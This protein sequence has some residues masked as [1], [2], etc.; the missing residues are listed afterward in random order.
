MPEGPPVPEGSQKEVAMGAVGG[1]RRQHD[2]LP[3]LALDPGHVDALERAV[4]TGTRLVDQADGGTELG[5]LG[6]VG[7]HGQVPGGNPCGPCS[8]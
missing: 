3:D 2:R 4:P 7:R 8:A 1:G 6:L 5:Q